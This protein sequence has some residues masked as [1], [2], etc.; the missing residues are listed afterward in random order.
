MTPSGCPSTLA[1]ELKDSNIDTSAILVSSPAGLDQPNTGIVPFEILP[2]DDSAIITYS[3]YLKVSASGLFS[4]DQYF[5]P[6]SLAVTCSSDSSLTIAAVGFNGL[7]TLV[8]Y[9]KNITAGS[10]QTY[11]FPILNTIPSN[12]G[13]SDYQFTFDDGGTYETAMSATNGLTYPA[14]GCVTIPCLSIDVKVETSQIIRFKIKG[15]VNGG[16]NQ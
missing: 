6:Y 1:Y 14:N 7:S 12:C 5:G 2:R 10:I 8:S 16:A 11:S 13:I 3:F 4:Y 15:T 9:D